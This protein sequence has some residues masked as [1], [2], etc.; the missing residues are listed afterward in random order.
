LPCLL[1]CL[2]IVLSWSF[3]VFSCRVSFILG[4]CLAQRLDKFARFNTIFFLSWLSFLVFHPNPNPNPDLK[5]TPSLN[6]TLNKPSSPPPPPF[7]NPLPPPPSLSAS[8]SPSP[9]PSPVAS[10]LPLLSPHPHTFNIQEQSCCA[11]HKTC[12]RGTGCCC[13]L[14][15]LV[16][17]ILA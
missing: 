6:L 15:F 13:V 14:I 4:P 2:V 16:L 11:R 17:G 5:S 1:S 12:L 8:A 10:P 7:S 9:T 3:L